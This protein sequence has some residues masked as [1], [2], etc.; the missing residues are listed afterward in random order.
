MTP[1]AGCTYSRSQDT[2]CCLLITGKLPA[3]RV[4]PACKATLDPLRR[5]MGMCTIGGLP[6][7]DC[8]RQ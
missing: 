1:A 4:M 2:T 6:L 3:W 8:L 5:T 7:P